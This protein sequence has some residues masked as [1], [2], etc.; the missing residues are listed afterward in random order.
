MSCYG[1]YVVEIITKLLVGS[2][3]VKKNFL[4]DVINIE[5][6]IDAYRCTKNKLLT[7]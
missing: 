5:K 7:F 2:I 4:S 6:A 3:F 1:S